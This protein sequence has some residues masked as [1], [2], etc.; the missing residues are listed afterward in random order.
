MTGNYDLPDLFVI[1]LQ[2]HLLVI[3]PQ[4]SVF[5]SGT[6]NL[7]FFPSLC[8]QIRYSL[9][10]LFPSSA[11]GEIPLDLIYGDEL[12]LN[13]MQM[14]IYVL[15]SYRNLGLRKRNALYNRS[16]CFLFLIP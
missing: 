2:E 10:Y 12:D 7:H 1:S 16:I 6:F 11:D 9:E 5:T 8:G 13:E 4:G 15:G 14:P 3:H